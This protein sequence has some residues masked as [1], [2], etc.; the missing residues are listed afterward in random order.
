MASKIS[1]IFHSKIY[2]FFWLMW[3]KTFFY[4]STY[5]ADVEPKTFFFRFIYNAI[6][7]GL[8]QDIILAVSYV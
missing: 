4:L 1:F 8:E 5:I 3:H 7:R 6:V 2:L